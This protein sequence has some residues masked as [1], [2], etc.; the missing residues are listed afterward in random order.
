MINIEIN[1]NNLLKRLKSIERNLN[2]LPW[3]SIGNVVRDS[4]HRNFDVEG[5]PVKWKPRKDNKPHPILN[6]SGRLKN[7]IYVEE[8]KNGVSIGSRVPY[9]AVHQYGYAPR[10]IPARPYLTIQEQ[11]KKQILNEIKKYILKK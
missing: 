6:K 4:V 3:Q 2:T 8:Q 5:R 1:S 10:N 11:D 9:Q 7:S